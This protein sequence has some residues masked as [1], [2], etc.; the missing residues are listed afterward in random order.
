MSDRCRWTQPDHQLDK[1]GC[2][3]GWRVSLVSL[4][5]EAVNGAELAGILPV[6]FPLARAG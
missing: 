3:L 2:R 4:S 5:C 1:N 6:G